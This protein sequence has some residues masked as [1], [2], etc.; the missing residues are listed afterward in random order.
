MTPLTS[1]TR[2]TRPISAAAN[3]IASGVRHPRDVEG[4]RSPAADRAGA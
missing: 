2:T 4:A 1:S 3:F